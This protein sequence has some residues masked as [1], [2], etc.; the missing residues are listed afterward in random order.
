MIRR[1]EFIKLRHEVEEA[2]TE[3]FQFAKTH[4]KN[5]NDYILFLARSDYKETTDPDFNPWHYDN[6]L[7]EFVDRHRVDFLL[8]YL[9]QQYNFQTVNSADSKF[10]LTLELMIY[11]H[12]W[13]SKHNLANFKKLA[14]LIDSKPYDWSVKVPEDSKYKFVK[15]NIRDVFERHNLKIFTIFKDCY[16]SQLRNAF[17]HSLYNF[18]LNGHNIVMENFNAKDYIIETMPFDEWTRIFLKSTLLQN[19]YHNKFNEEIE[20][21]EVGKEYEVI[22]EYGTEKAIGIISYNKT[23]KRFNGKLK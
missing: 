3:A 17:S 14:D 19:Y 2:V 10:T 18:G 7:Q 13:E 1:E 6:S 9:N 23:L 21:L 15:N 5:P 20:N 8:T 4:E 11:S 12:L 22:M 16:K